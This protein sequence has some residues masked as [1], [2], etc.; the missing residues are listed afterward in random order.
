MSPP[1]NPAKRQDTK[2]TPEA[3]RR[4]NQQK[5]ESDRRRQQR[6]VERCERDSATI[7]EKTA[8]IID[9][10]REV[11]DLSAR[12]TEAE[13]KGG[14]YWHEK[15]HLAKAY[16][17]VDAKRAQLSKQLERTRDHLE[18]TE[19]DLDGAQTAL[20]YERGRNK[21]LRAREKAL[22]KEE[23]KQRNQ[24][25]TLMRATH[26]TR[27]LRARLTDE[28]A[29]ARAAQVSAV[30]AARDSIR[31]DRALAF[32]HR[33]RD[34][35][36]HR[37]A[38]VAETSRLS[39]LLDVKD[40]ALRDAAELRRTQRRKLDAHYALARNEKLALE[41]R[42]KELEEE[43]AQA[44]VS[45]GE[46]D[47]PDQVH[48][49][50]DITRIMRGD[51]DIKVRESSDADVSPF[52][53]LV[54]Q[55]AMQMMSM[56]LSYET[57]AAVYRIIVCALAP[58]MDD[59]HF[60]PASFFQTYLKQSRIVHLLMNAVDIATARDWL[61][62]AGDGTSD[63]DVLLGVQELFASVFKI[64]TVTGVVKD[65][66]LGGYAKSLGL[67]ADEEA[68][69]SKA[70]L[71]LLRFVL[72]SA[73]SLFKILHPKAAVTAA[74]L[75][76]AVDPT[77]IGLKFVKLLHADGAASAQ[78]WARLMADVKREELNEQYAG[79]LDTLT[80]SQRARLFWCVV[81]NCI[82]HDLALGATWARKAAA[83]VTAEESKG[84]VE[85]VRAAGHASDS[86]SH[87]ANLGQCL[88][89]LKKYLSRSEGYCFG[90]AAAFHM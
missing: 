52:P 50:V 80:P 58:D 56:D 54:R 19:D 31:M 55:I 90:K 72:T 32:E 13:R 66:A 1:R 82:M 34:E 36:R 2:D 40:S 14:N 88:H 8:L 5:R 73:K 16:D 6:H 12:L 70:M 68:E 30:D 46:F 49:Q 83:Q 51:P 43:L 7:R 37:R 9:L 26:A 48:I 81:T 38:I 15:T 23:A 63:H 29:V 65:I 87:A 22:E 28:L 27:E 41:A 84:A 77:N 67:T 10:T 17:E 74:H 11:D 45:T 57:A 42:V 75:G 60:P 89:T 47:E 71:A 4:R 86:F 69:G 79:D 61:S 25:R 53:L 39:V 85:A 64:Q 20:M 18:T 33:Q 76:A 62:F 44:R 35:Q 59:R 78:K 21:S 3:M 24:Q